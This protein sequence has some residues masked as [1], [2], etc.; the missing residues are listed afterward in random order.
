MSGYQQ[1]RKYNQQD[2]YTE[3][4]DDLT[5]AAGYAI[6]TTPDVP[7]EPTKQNLSKGATDDIQIEED[8]SDESSDDGD[9]TEMRSKGDEDSGDESDIDLSEQLAKMEK[10]D[11]PKPKNS[12]IVVPTT[13]NEID[14]YNCPVADLE[15]KLELD[16]GI[17]DVLLFHPSNIGIMNAKVSLDRIRLAG[18]ITFHLASERTIVVESNPNGGAEQMGG[19]PFLLDEGSLLL[20]RLKQDD[21]IMST[22]V[23]DVSMEANETCVIPLGKI[24]EVFGPVSKPLYTIR[25]TKSLV[26][27]R[28]KSENIATEVEGEEKVPEEANEEGGDAKMDAQVEATEGEGEE[29]VPKEANEEV[30]DAKE[31]A[32]DESKAETPKEAA[33]E[34]VESEPKIPDPWSK[35]GL[36]TQWIKSVPRLE[37]YYS[38][39]Q[40]KMMDTQSIVRNSRKACG[41]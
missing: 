2:G 5:F 12:R 30:G 39:D 34:E 38:E 4:V 10:E 3:A 33:K 29:K 18:N 8:T 11:Q 24:L 35:D 22:L 27:A 40:V 32:Q 17:S 13:Q 15:K 14:L 23:G 6:V 21:K 7:P 36:L 26:Q 31:D 19:H 37:V 25:L 20:L 28:Q 9:K 41:M 1:K 16:L